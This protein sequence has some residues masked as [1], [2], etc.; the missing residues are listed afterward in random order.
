MFPNRYEAV[1]VLSLVLVSGCGEERPKPDPIIPIEQVPARVVEE[2]KKALPGYT[3][4]AVYQ[5]KVDGKNAYEFKGKNKQGKLRE[6]EL[7]ATGE[8][9]AIE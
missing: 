5:M 2:A 4:Y 7:S 3:F 1:V 9:L 8:V 6:V